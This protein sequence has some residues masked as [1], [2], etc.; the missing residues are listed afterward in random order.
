MES[1]TQIENRI[2]IRDI[3]Q[4]VVL[5][6]SSDDF[7]IRKPFSSEFYCP[8][9]L[10]ITIKGKTFQMFSDTLDKEKIAFWI[11]RYYPN[12]DFA[13]NIPTELQLSEI[14]QKPEIANH[15]ISMQGIDL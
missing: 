13:G 5:H 8:Y 10:K 11:L 3:N 2:N 4:K 14:R 15:R 6:L 7:Q 1:I 12:A 9:L